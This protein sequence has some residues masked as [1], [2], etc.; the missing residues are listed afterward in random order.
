MAATCYLLGVSTRRMDKLVQSLGIGR[1]QRLGEVRCVL[2]AADL[3]PVPD[4]EAGVDGPDDR[5]GAGVRGDLLGRGEQPRRDRR[6][7]G[8]LEEP[9]VEDGFACVPGEQHPSRRGPRVVRDE[10]PGRICWRPRRV[11]RGTAARAALWTPDLSD[12]VTEVRL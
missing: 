1:L 8:A 11:L 4:P 3:E 5:R 2:E 10:R 6:V 12:R 9:Q 7:V